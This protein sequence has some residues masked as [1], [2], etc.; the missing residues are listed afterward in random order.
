MVCGLSSS[1][2]ALTLSTVGATGRY[3][4]SHAG[5][6][7]LLTCLWVPARLP[8]RVSPLQCAGTP[9]AP[10]ATLLGLSLNLSAV[11]RPTSSAIPGE[12]GIPTSVQPP[13]AS[14]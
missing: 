6:T 14:R 11:Q 7:A 5:N 2:K 8:D 1:K 10:F 3:A 9:P 4:H 12:P 13:R